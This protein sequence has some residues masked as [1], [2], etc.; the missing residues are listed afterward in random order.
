MKVSFSKLF[1]LA[2]LLLAAAAAGNTIAQQTTPA[3]QSQKHESKSEKRAAKLL[4]EDAKSYLD[5]AYIEFNKQK[6][7]YDQKLEAKTKQEQKDLA[8]NYAA[9]L[10]SR[11]SLPEAD[12]YYL[13]MLHYLAGNADAALAAM[14]KYL[15]GTTSGENAQLARAVVVLFATR[16]NLIP[17]AERAVA[18]YSKTQPQVL[19]EWFGMEALIAEA[20]QK[21]K[22]YAGALKHSQEM[23]KIADLAAAD[24]TTNASRRDDMLYKASSFIAE[25]YVQMGK[26]PDALAAIDAL[27]KLAISI[28]S[29]SLLRLANIRLTGLDRSVDTKEIFNEPAP[30]TASPLPELVATQWIDQAPVKLADLHGQVVLLDFWAPWCGPCRYTFPRLQRWHNSYKDKGLVI[31]GLTNYFGNIDGRR[32]TPGEE[33]AYL[34]TFKKQQHL[35][36]GFVVSDSSANDRNYG[37]FSIPM[38]FLIDRRGNVRF[39]AMGASEPEITGLGKMLDKVMNEDTDKNT[40]TVTA[41]Q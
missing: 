4:F 35:P 26:K 8:A 9:V 36:Y 23:L 18:D 38:S 16:Q 37:V 30:E 10:E 20:S 33:I 34:R 13:G 2:A 17:E 3:A 21:A 5:R 6:I 15:A 27:R 7:P 28:P 29:G 12:F 19:A 39:I 24:K 31:L 32:A 40:N 41:R 25:A 14:R 11:K 1:V 22:D